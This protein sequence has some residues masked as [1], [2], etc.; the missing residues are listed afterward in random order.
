MLMRLFLAPLVK[1]LLR[2]MFTE[3]R[4]AIIVRA[5]CVERFIFTRD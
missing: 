4:G 5:L 2:F 3:E 1:S